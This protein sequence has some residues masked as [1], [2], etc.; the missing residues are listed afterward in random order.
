MRALR[1]SATIF[2]ALLIAVVVLGSCGGTGPATTPAQSTAPAT[3]PAQSVAPAPHYPLTVTDDRG[4]TITMRLAPARVVSLAPS[5]TEIVFALGAQDRLVAVD[6]YSDHPA[7]AKALPKLGGFRTSPERILAYRPDLIFAISSGDLAEQLDQRGQPVVVFD[8]NDLEGV[9]AN[10]GLIGTLLDREEAARALVDRMRARIAAVALKAGGATTRPRVLH[11][12]DSTDP[13]R[14]YVAGPRNFIDSII[15]LV[16]GQNVGASAPTKFPRFSPE[17]IVRSDP[18]VIV[19]G[20]A[21]YG[22]TPAVVAARPGYAVIDAVRNGRVLPIDEDIV[23]RP[24][25]RLADGVEAYARLVH[26]E[27]FGTGP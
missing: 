11:E 14:V 27:I 1:R 3:T 4:K 2:T 26:P 9:Y 18:Q 25:P 19:L 21:R 6:D 5:A 24:G 20:D 22:V 16:G 13:A 7:E 8:P 15:T 17:E 12:V 10:I 23:S